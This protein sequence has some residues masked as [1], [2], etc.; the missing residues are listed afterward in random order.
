MRFDR[1]FEGYV[2]GE[3]HRSRG[4]TITEADIVQFAG[5]SGDFYP[6]HIDREYAKQTQFGERIAH[7]MLTLSAATGLWVMEPGCVLAFYGIDALRFVRPV[8]IG[9]TIYVES[10]VKQLTERSD[11]AGLVTVH[12]QILNQHGE[13][14]VDALVHMLVA[15]EGKK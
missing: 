4:R 3:R 11:T 13:T 10:E 9:D 6:L 15:R 14:V 7:G 2:V 8:K 1:P 12:Q 5:V